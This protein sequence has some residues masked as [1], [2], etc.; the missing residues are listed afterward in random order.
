MATNCPTIKIDSNDTGLRFAIERCL[1]E[2][3][4]VASAGAD[5]VWYAMEPNSYSD[6]GPN[7]STTARNPINPSRQRQKGVVTDMEA[8]ASF[9][10]D[11]T[12][13]NHMLFLE[14]F[15][16][17]QAREK[18]STRMIDGVGSAITAVTANTFATTAGVAATFD[19]KTILRSSG[20]AESANNGVFVVTSVAG[21]VITV[22]GPLTPNA[23]PPA[24]ATVREVGFEFDAGDA[25][26]DVTAGVV[27]LTSTAKNLLQLG[28]IPGEWIYVGGDAN[29]SYFPNQRGF[30]RI[31]S[32]SSN[33]MILDKIQWATP[34][35]DAGAAISLRIFTGTVIRNE[36]DP[37]LIERPSFQFERTLGKDA[38]GIQSQYVT[39]AVANELTI[40]LTTADKATIEMGFM[41]CGGE[42]RTGLE[43]LKPGTRPALQSGQSAFNT[44]TDIRRIA[45]NVIGQTVPLFFYATE[46]Q[47]TIGNNASGLKALGT[48]GNADVSLGTFDVGGNVTGYFQDV[49]ALR[50][51]RENSSVT[52]DCILVKDNKGIVFD[53]P[54]M[55]MSNGM[56]NV[57]QDQA[58]TIPLDIAAAQSSFGHTLLY[59]NFEYLPNAA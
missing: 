49:R 22:N 36:E 40:D 16:A 25:V 5:P 35:S 34:V 43:G 30:A 8:S 38:N 18:S 29:G 44:A 53:I 31:G 57:E 7:I 50:A 27:S 55:T 14:G 19:P 23:A 52:M 41:A 20:F 21:G 11:L 58:V 6:F 4:T 13:Q 28:L 45:F 15:M 12:H 37:N 51:V 1:R 3:P 33:R 48:L 17:A 54:L 26:L 24:T 32:I 56:P 42:D 2:L 39:G 10:M 46:F 9:E 47:L 59:V